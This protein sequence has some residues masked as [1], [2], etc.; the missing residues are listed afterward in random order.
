MQEEEQIYPDV[1]VALT[2]G[3]LR[4]EANKCESS[5]IRSLAAAFLSGKSNVPGA[6]DCRT[7]APLLVLRFGDTTMKNLRSRPLS[8]GPLPLSTQATG[9][10]N[11]ARFEDLPAG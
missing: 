4:L 6:P 5:K 11:S 3:L 1:N 10:Q 8:S 9:M 7:V 2:E